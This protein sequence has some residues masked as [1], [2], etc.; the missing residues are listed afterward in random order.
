M[1][2][3]DW[4]Y[5]SLF[6]GS[7]ASKVVLLRIIPTREP[8]KK[9]EKIKSGSYELDL[10]FLVEQN[11]KNVHDCPHNTEQCQELLEYL[12]GSVRL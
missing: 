8:N 4:H 7:E 3:R 11:A 10:I 2:K 9:V 6:L 12:R 1:Q 5:V